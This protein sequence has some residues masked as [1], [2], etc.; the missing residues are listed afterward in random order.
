MKG[1]VT[2]PTSGVPAVVLHLLN[3][4]I[5]GLLKVILSIGG[6]GLAL[7]EV[8][9]R[10]DVI[11]ELLLVL[12]LGALGEGGEHVGHVDI[13]LFG[14]EVVDLNRVLD[15]VLVLELEVV[16]DDALVLLV[17]E[18]NVLVGAAIVFNVGAEE[19]GFVDFLSRLHAHRGEEP[20]LAV[21]TL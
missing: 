9:E 17:Q 20:G 4:F 10:L 5:E 3:V 1:A 7:D 18:E 16:L 8:H 15:E 14:D 6:E 21:R 12:E 13:G 19:V 11:E 2:L